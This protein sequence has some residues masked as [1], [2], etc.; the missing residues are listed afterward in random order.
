MFHQPLVFKFYLLVYALNMHFILTFAQ[1]KYGG[2][3]KMELMQPIAT[4][5]IEPNS[6]LVYEVKYDG[7]RATL[8]WSTKQIKIISRNNTELT[9]NFPEIISYCQQIQPKITNLL[10]IQLDGELVIL[11]NQFQANFAAIQ[12]RGRDRKSIRLN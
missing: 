6:D 9:E 4:S 10:P 3:K 7:F 2:G 8:Q 11:N 5:R 12:K 1:L